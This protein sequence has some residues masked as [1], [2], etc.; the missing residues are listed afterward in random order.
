MKKLVLLA[1]AGMTTLGAMAQTA[2]TTQP[3][4]LRSQRQQLFEQKR[5]AEMTSHQQRIQILQAAD[6]CIRA[7]AT[8]QAYRACEQTE[9]TQRQAFR[10]Q[11]KAVNQQLRAQ[12]EQLRFQQMQMAQ[13]GDRR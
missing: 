10:A 3:T 13:L 12:Y 11:Q 6:G 9:R 1:M 2:T 4:D 8:P 7:A 5:S